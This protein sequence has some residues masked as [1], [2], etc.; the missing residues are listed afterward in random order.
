PIWPAYSHTDGR[1][2]TRRAAL[3]SPRMPHF[4]QDSFPHR[5]VPAPGIRD[6]LQ[7]A[8]WAVRVLVRKPKYSTHRISS[9]VCAWNSGGQFVLA[10]LASLTCRPRLAACSLPP[11]RKPTGNL[12]SV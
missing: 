2:A 5:R 7:L 9:R 11:S 8:S 10:E 3:P 4:S 6:Y 1:S 12:V